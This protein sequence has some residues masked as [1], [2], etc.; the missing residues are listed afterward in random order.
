MLVN[1]RVHEAFINNIKEQLPVTVRV[2]ALPGKTLKAHVK[3][4]DNVAQPQ[5]WMSPD[6]KVYRSFAEIDDYLADLKLKPGLSAVCTI[7]TDLKAE[8]VLAVPVQAVLSPL[9]RG[10]KPRCFVLTPHGP[11]G[12]DVELGLTDERYV[13]IK[14]GL[15]EGEDVILNPRI[16]VADKDKKVSRD[17]DKIV[18]TG[19]KPGAGP[20]RP[21]GDKSGSFGDR[22][23]KSGGPKE[24]SPMPPMDQ[25]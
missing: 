16:L 25:E 1:L 22:K 2:D 12:R 10:G 4:V 20:G 15:S 24:G 18:P 7:Y 14:S 8:H 23:G 13:Q 9:E 6:V 11:E 3:M 19:G 21:G 5:D 17:N